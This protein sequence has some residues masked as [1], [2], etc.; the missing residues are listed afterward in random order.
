MIVRDSKIVSAVR[1]GSLIISTIFNGVRKVSSDIIDSVFGAG[2][3]NN[4]SGW[5]NNDGWKN[6]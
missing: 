6:G 3:W 4:N 1:Y 2:Y 5:N